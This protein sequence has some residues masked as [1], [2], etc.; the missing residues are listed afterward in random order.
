MSPIDL[1]RSLVTIRD[2]IAIKREGGRRGKLLISNIV[3]DLSNIPTK[4][5]EAIAAIAALGAGSNDFE[6]SQIARFSAYAA[7]YATLLTAA[8]GAQ[9]SLASVTEF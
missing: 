4:Y 1:E 7:E 2:E 8:Q 5:A 3:S 9:A 6:R